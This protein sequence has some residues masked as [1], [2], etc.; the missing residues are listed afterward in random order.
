[1]EEGESPEGAA[2]RELLEES[3]FEAA[4]LRL[5]DAWQPVNKID[6]AVY[7]FVAHGLTPTRSARNP[8]DPTQI[9]IYS[10]AR[11]LDGKPFLKIDDD[12][13]LYRLYQARADPRE[14]ARI[15]ALLSPPSPK[16]R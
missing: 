10:A 13:L 12:E 9:R 16:H 3:G 14:R 15:L 4:E 6:W 5:W 1:M 7:L 8:D 2:R 11:L